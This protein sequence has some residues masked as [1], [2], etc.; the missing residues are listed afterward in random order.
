MPT[1]VTY[2]PDGFGEDELADL[3]RVGQRLSIVVDRHNQ[4]WITHDLL[5]ADLG[6]NTG[7]KVLTG[8]IRRGTGVE[9][10]AVPWSSET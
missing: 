1:F 8:Q 2:R 6:A 9:L 4:W 7:P 10:T 5:C 3:A